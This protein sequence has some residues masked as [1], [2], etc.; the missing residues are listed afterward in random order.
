MF[1]WCPWPLQFLWF[2]FLYSTGVSE[3]CLCLGV[4]LCTCFHHL[5]VL[6]II[7]MVG[8]S[9]WTFCEQDKLQV[10]VFIAK[11][12]SKSLHRG[13][14]CFQNMA[15]S[16]SLSS[17]T[18]NLLVIDFMLLSYILWSFYYTGFLPHSQYFHPPLQPFL[19]V[20]IPSNVI[21]SILNLF[22]PQSTWKSYFS[23][24]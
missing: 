7:V 9:P 17:I 14:V 13:L 23:S 19:S 3:L 20:F 22:H 11:F 4:G 10:R 1:P 8:S 5:L 21:T 12:V 15:I 2:F 16:K 6:L 18:G 24:P